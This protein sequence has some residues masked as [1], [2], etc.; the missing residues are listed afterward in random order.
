MRKHA[1]L[2]RRS[3]F[4]VLLVGPATIAVLV[5]IIAPLLLVLGVSVT[6]WQPGTATFTFTGLQNYQRLLSEAD[7]RA[8]LVNTGLYLAIVVPM[9]VVLGFASALLV[10][11]VRSAGAIYRLL[12]FL[13]TVATLAAMSVAWQTLLSP[14]VGM[15]PQMM[16]AVGLVPQNWLQQSE[17]ALPVLAL[18]GVWAEFGFA[19]LFFL[20]GLRSIPPELY[21]AG[22]LD[23]IGGTLD[24]VWHITLPHLRPIFAFVLVFASIHALRAFDT[25]AVITRGGPENTT[26]LYLYYIY[27]EA[28]A[29]FRTGLAAAATSLL[30]LLVLVVSLLQM[31]WS[32]GRSS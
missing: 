11:R 4:G 2:V 20:A 1:A 19:M 15:L 30:V 29:L 23:G 28:F 8:A 25:I 17:T 31:R 7:F 10:S 27:Q 22:M 12:L 24:S 26:L 13:P 18:I 5:L 6:D 14:S 21:E 32:R 9:T 3:S 16:R